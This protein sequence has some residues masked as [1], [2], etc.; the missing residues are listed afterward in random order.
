MQHGVL[1]G[2][3]NLSGRAY[4]RAGL[5]RPLGA[6]FDGVQYTEASMKLPARGLQSVWGCR[7]T[8]PEWETQEVHMH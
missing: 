3:V 2:T 8:D 5:P 7:G 6:H 1:T 4:A